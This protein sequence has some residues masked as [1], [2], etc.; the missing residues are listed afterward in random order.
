MTSRLQRAL[1]GST[2]GLDGLEQR[3]LARRAALAAV[4]GQLRI[5]DLLLARGKARA[6]LGHVDDRLGI[7]SLG[8]P[9]FRIHRYFPH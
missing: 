8:R 9:R 5:S 2:R 6:K 4:A 1:P 3:F 7:V